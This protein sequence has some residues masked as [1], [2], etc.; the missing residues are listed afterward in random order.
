MR[1]FDLAI[2]D[3]PLVTRKDMREAL[4]QL[5]EPLIPYFSEGRTRL[6]LGFT[7][8]GCAA[9]TA[10]L[11]GFSRI[12]WGLVPLAAGGGDSPLWDL[13]AQGIRNGTDPA[14]PEYWDAVRD[15]D[16]KLVEMAAM[17]FALALAP[18]RVWEPLSVP[19]RQRFY[20]W[21]NQ[22]NRRELHDCNW[23]F[24]NVMVNL[25]FKKA[26]LPYDA[27]RMNEHLDRIDAYYLSDGWYSDGPQAHCDYY[28]P[29]AIYFYGLLYSVWMKDEDPI[30]A[31]MY[32][33]RASVFAQAFIHWF[34]G[35]GS[36]LP[37]GRS[38]TYRFAQSAFWSAMAYAEVEA[39]PMGVMKGLVLRNLRWWFRQPIFRADGTLT[40]GY[41]YPNLVMAE[42]YNAPGSPYWALKAF[43]PLALPEQHP[44][45]RAGELP[46]PRL[47][48]LSIQQAPRLVICRQE[49]KRHVVAFNAGHRSTNEHTHTSAKYEK[50]AYSNMFGFSVPRA[51]WGL[52]QGAF[53]SM[54]AMSEGDRMYRVKRTAEESEIR[55]HGV[56]YFRWKP[57][58]DVEVRT[59]LIP[60][61][62][63][64]VRV[65]RIET[66]R[67]LDLADGGFALGLESLAERSRIAQPAAAESESRQARVSYPWGASGIRLLHGS[68]EA[69]LIYPNANTNVLHARTVI[70]TVTA[71]LQ[72]G[73]VGWL[74]TAVYGEPGSDS[75]A[76]ERPPRAEADGEALTVVWG[77]S[78]EERL[79]IE[80]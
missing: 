36:A 19:E 74:A 31:G 13:V 25:G 80:M 16:Q 46:L 72:P 20:D 39:F 68:G 65:H 17:G 53:D 37:F 57:W 51:E 6:E 67:Y 38:L 10:E 71:S 9:E 63:W 23:K 40:I 2:R 33:E 24:F 48:E 12:L 59:W 21:L 62:P 47:P 4:R 11:E 64:H 41:A 35:D 15:Y 78:G 69:Q 79:R 76:W 34:A 1:A 70:P 73:T 52:S 28:V 61:T 18:D 8:S 54:L 14:H 45:W 7:G 56:L 42:N 75:S 50:F 55:D 49:E 58:K 22:M 77:G 5:C 43:L 3:N 30:R 29:F 60:G 66:G 26:G 32:R 44:F 27:K